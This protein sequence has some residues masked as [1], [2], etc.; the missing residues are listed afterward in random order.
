MAV[1]SDIGPEGISACHG[2]QTDL[3]IIAHL[4]HGLKC[5]IPG[6]LDGPFVVL[7][8]QQ[9]T[10]ETDDGFVVGKDADD[11]GA[12]FDFAVETLDGIGRVELCPMLFGKGH[13]GEHIVLQRR[14]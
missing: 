12:S 10:D 6:A 11:L 4:G 3:G 13:I 2:G 5:H 7:F 9:S 8:E 1:L 14:P